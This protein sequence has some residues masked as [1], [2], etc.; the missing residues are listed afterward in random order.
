MSLN[1]LTDSTPKPWMKI[2]C[3][4]I[5]CPQ[6]IKKDSQQTH[7]FVAPSSQ[8]ASNDGHVLSYN[9][10]TKET[11]WKAITGTQGPQG[12]QG[13]QGPPGPAGPA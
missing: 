11:E 6:G 5:V 12:P 2:H 13:E 9:D 7:T 4:E 3:S 10:T 8:D 1:K